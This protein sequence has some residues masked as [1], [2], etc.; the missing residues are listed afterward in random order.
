MDF[1]LAFFHKKGIRSFTHFIQST[2]A[3]TFLSSFSAFIKMASSSLVSPLPDFTRMDS[4]S[5]VSLPPTYTGTESRSSVS[6]PSVS[7]P[8]GYSIVSEEFSSD[9]MLSYNIFFL[10]E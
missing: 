6:Q 7:P 4:R 5:S 3:A 1:S 9:Y 8:F 10:F 2:S